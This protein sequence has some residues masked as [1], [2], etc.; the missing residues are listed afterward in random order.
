MPRKSKSNSAGNEATGA[1]P[2]VMSLEAF[3]ADFARAMT[4][5]GYLVDV[6][7]G[8]A[9]VGVGWHDWIGAESVDMEPA[10][11]RYLKKPSN[12]DAIIDKLCTT[13]D[14]NMPDNSPRG[15]GS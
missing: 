11:A 3:A 7:E 1:G 14:R 8:G 9:L 10:Y 15:W 13:T 2:K 12:L 4:T 5:A 6:R